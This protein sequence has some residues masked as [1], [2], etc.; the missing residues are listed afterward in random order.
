MKKHNIFEG[1]QAQ[2][3]KEYNHK[4]FV[5]IEDGYYKHGASLFL[6][7][8]NRFELKQT[9]KVLDIG[10]GSLR[11]GKHLMP[12]LESE[13]YYGVEPEEKYLTEGIKW[14]M[15]DLMMN[16]K[17]PKFN[18][19]PD[20][21]FKMFEQT[22]DLALA[23]QVFIHCSPGQL[24]R[25]LSNLK[26]CLSKDGKFLFHVRFGEQ[27]KVTSWDQAKVCKLPWYEDRPY[28]FSDNCSTD[29]SLS[30]LDELLDNNGFKRTQVFCRNEYKIQM[31]PPS[32]LVEAKLK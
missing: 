5:C 6:A 12:F 18:N 31:A 24:K 4:S 11:I 7:L 29:Y 26:Y 22:F 28:R 10:C 15:S 1:P 23:S 13:K 2:A 14:E 21:D 9:D 16:L 20:F 8:I 19:S 32:T 3:M 30:D 17:K 27:T 25:C